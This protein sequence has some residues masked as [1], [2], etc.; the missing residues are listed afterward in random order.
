MQQR[1]FL[2]FGLFISCLISHDTILDA[3]LFPYQNIIKRFI[4]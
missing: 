3:T 4:F 2:K 1:C